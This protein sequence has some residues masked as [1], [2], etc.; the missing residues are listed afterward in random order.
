M[1]WI[2]CSWDEP[3]LRFTH[4]RPMGSSQQG[5]FTGRMRHGFGQ[6]FMGTGFVY[7]F[8]SSVYRISEKPYLV[9]GVAILWGWIKSAVAREP[10]Y[11][12]LEF[13]RF[14][15]RYQMRSLLAGKKKATQAL[16]DWNRVNIKLT[17][18]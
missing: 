15:R 12:D 18:E 17:H 7:I 4:L 5:I 6:Y 14:L 1:G 9:G 16:D 10:R 8:V 11:D 2:A 3:E 13:R